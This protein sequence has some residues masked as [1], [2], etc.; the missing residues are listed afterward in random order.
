M[1]AIL[2][3]FKQKLIDSWN[4]TDKALH[5]D[6]KN[7][8]KEH[9]DEKFDIGYSY[10]VSPHQYYIHKNGLTREQGEIIWHGWY[11]VEERNE[12]AA[13]K[14][15]K[16]LEARISNVTGEIKEINNY[17]T[18]NGKGWKVHGEKAN[19]VVLQIMAGG[20]NHGGW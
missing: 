3:Q 12:K 18:E 10:N 17:V 4:A 8:Y 5:D 9:K 6:F 11:G 2:E 7:W 20:Y 15:V 14:F 1:N 19:A 13:E 16:N